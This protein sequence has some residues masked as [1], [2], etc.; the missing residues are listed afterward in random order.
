[1]KI[2]ARERAH[3]RAFIKLCYILVILSALYAL[4]IFIY[5]EGCYELFVAPHQKG[6]ILEHLF[7]SLIVVISGN[8]LLER[9][10]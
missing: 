1:M 7:C 9:G 6:I 10:L 2:T 3:I 8:V 4:K 5:P